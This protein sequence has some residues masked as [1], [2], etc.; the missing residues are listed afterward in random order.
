M[1]KATAKTKKTVMKIH[2]APSPNMGFTE[3]SKEVAAVL[4][5]AIRGPNQN[6]VMM[7]M[8]FETFVPR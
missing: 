1:L 2:E 7:S 5:T 8:A 4:G 3:N 6:T